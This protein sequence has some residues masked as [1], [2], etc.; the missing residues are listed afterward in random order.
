M[1]RVRATAGLF[2]QSGGAMLQEPPPP[3][4]HRRGAQVA[5]PDNLSVGKP[6]YRPENHFASQ[7][8][9]MP[10]ATASGDYIKDCFFR[11][12][13]FQRLGMGRPRFSLHRSL[14]NPPEQ[15]KL[16]MQRTS[17]TLH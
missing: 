6:F 7:Y 12:G 4:A 15:G 11:R 16:F 8:F 13:Q 1:R 5:P 17:V 3:F 10:R 9:H 14:P 2:G